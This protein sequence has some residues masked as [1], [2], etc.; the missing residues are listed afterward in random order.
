MFPNN[1]TRLY[2][3]FA[4]LK[5]VPTFAVIAILFS[6]CHSTHI[7]NTATQPNIVIILADDLGYGDITGYGASLVNTPNVD[8][9]ISEGRKFTNAHS[10]SAVCT[11]SRYGLLTGE[12]AWRTF[13]QSGVLSTSSALMIDP[14]R[15]TIGDYLQQQGYVT[16]CV[17]K[18]HLGMQSQRPVDWNA[19]LTPGPL[20]V[21][22]DYFF[23]V[24]T[25]PNLPPFVYVEDHEVVDRL[26]GEL[27]EIVNGVEV[28]GISTPRLPEEIGRRTTEKAVQ[29]IEENQNEPFF[30]YMA[31]SSIHFPLTPDTEFVGT[32]AL[33]PYGD[34]VHEFDWTVGEIL[35][36]L[37]R[38]DLAEDTIVIVTSDN[39]PW[40]YFVCDTAHE[41]AGPFSGAKGLIKEGG[42]RVPFVARWPE[43]IPAGSETSRLFDLVDLYATLAAARGGSEPE[44]AGIDSTDR[45]YAFI[46]DAIEAPDPQLDTTVHHSWLGKFALRRGDWKY[47]PAQTP[48]PFSE[49]NNDIPPE[50]LLRSTCDPD[51]DDQDEV[52]QLYYLGTDPGELNN[53]VA[54]FPE[55]AANMAEVLNEIIAGETQDSR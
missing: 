23:G 26:P 31:T 33:G 36:A 49:P 34:F 5:C 12:Y 11:P 52:E 10:P 29:F 18:W 4:H 20:E 44:G 30:L 7:R 46:D 16:G 40:S 43:V 39:G 24:P 13:L 54:H 1:H 42:H 28:S 41:A 35:D 22:F 25:S 47:I 51:F 8:R 55:I 14:D 3:Y 2:V 19:P 21:G 17:G 53:V 50:E 27:I 15:E 45:W 9:L 38:N 6:S 37:D 32:S 48:I